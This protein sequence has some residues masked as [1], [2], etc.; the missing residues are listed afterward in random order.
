M[1][2]IMCPLITI[3]EQSLLK[4]KWRP[5]GKDDTTT[6]GRGGETIALIGHCQT[7]ESKLDIRIMCPLVTKAYSSCSSVPEGED[8]VIVRTTGPKRLHSQKAVSGSGNMWRTG[9]WP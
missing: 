1:F 9:T 4:L 2:S 7:R 3:C 8:D 5:G 6:R